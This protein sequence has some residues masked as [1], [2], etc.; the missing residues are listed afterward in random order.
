MKRLLALVGL[1]TIVSVAGCCDRPGLFNRSYYSN[2]SYPPPTYTNP[3]D[4]APASGQTF[5]QQYA[6]P[7]PQPV[8]P[9]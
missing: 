8:K 5:T 4:C 7:L 2:Y 1:L 9:Q 3:C 6:Q